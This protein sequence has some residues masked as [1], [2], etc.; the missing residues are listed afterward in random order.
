MG[1]VTTTG[2]SAGLTDDPNDPALREI[3]RGGQQKKYLILSDEERAKGFV[4]PLRRSYTHLKCGGSTRM[5]L[6]LCETYSRDPSFYGGT[7]CANCG[8]HFNL[9]G[10]ARPDDPT[11]P[12]EGKTKGWGFHFVWDEDGEG[13]GS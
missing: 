9:R 7:F 5:G 2:D 11:K 1:Y 3:Q 13:V 6:A 8:A 12:E 4:R 10:Y